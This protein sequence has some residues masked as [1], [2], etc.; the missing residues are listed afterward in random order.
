MMRR[1]SRAPLPTLILVL[2]V[3][4]ALGGVAVAETFTGTPGDDR[5][6]GSVR[7]DQLYGEEGDDELAGERGNDYLEAGPA[8]TSSS[9]AR[10]ATS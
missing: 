10:A 2:L 9:A 8:T 5:L 7:P 4:L 6:S 3:G 1:R